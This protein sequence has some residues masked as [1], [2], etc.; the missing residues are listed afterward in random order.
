MGLNFDHTI[1]VWNRLCFSLWLCIGYFGYYGEHKVT[2]KRSPSFRFWYQ[3]PEILHKHSNRQSENLH[4]FCFS[5]FGFFSNVNENKSHFWL[6]CVAGIFKTSMLREQN[7]EWMR[8]IRSRGGVRRAKETFSPH[9]LPTSPQ[10]FLH[11][12]TLSL[13][14]SL[15]WSLRQEKEGKRSL[16][17]LFLIGRGHVL[18][19][20]SNFRG[21]KCAIDVWLTYETGYGFTWCEVRASR[22]GRTPQPTTVGSTS[23]RRKASKMKI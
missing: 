3:I 17:R 19:L 1:L 23:P 4:D 16:R 12:Q 10:F 8:N 22:F 21:L 5:N 18:E 20:C 2:L 14:R 9:P 13:A 11:T 15:V 6:A 7:C